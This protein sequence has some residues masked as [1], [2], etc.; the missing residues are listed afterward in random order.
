[1]VK[2]GVH[3]RNGMIEKKDSTGGRTPPLNSSLTP[4]TELIKIKTKVLIKLLKP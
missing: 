4:A 1:M 2:F 3:P